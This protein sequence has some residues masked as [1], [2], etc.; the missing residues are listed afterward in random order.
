MFIGYP[1]DTETGKKTNE[2]RRCGSETVTGPID[3][4]ADIEA[5]VIEAVRFRL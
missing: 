4:S 2:R 1:F 3:P 5:A